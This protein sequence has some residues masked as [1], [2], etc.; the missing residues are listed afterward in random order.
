M[1]S[2]LQMIESLF[3]AM[4]RVWSEGKDWK[5]VYE[6]GTRS[7]ITQKGDCELRH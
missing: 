1:H 4:G 5:V 6:N 3:V 7:R 2:L